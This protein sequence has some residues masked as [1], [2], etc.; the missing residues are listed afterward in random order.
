MTFLSLSFHRNERATCQPCAGTLEPCHFER[1]LFPGRAQVGG[2]LTWQ[3][4]EGAERRIVVAMT[5]DVL[6][7]LRSEL[8]GRGACESDDVV[9]RSVLCQWGLQQ[10]R[11]RVQSGACLPAEGLILGSLGGPASCRAR[12]LLEIAG[13][14]AETEAEQAVRAT[15]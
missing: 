11:E 10:Y 7:Q 6:A 2:L 12:R 14:L 3:P 13:L 9:V 4:R 15:R 5:W 1:Q 8:S